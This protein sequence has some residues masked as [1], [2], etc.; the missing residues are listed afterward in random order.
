MVP[1][2]DVVLHHWNEA[3]RYGMSVAVTTR[4]GGVSP[5]PYDSLNL[6]LHVGDDPANVIANRERAA[7]AFGVDLDTTVFAHQVHGTGCTFVD[8]G[9]RGRGARGQ[10]DAIVGTDI[11]V[12]TSDDVTLVM[13]VA[14]CVPMVLI[15]PEAK[16]MAAAHAGWRGTADG[17]AANVVAAMAQR[18][19]R[20]DR[21]V[22]Y[23]GP[24]VSSAHYQ[25]GAD[26][27][28][29]LTA[30]VRPSSLDPGV[31][32]AD[33]AAH[34]RVDLIAANR[35]QLQLAGV[36]PGHLFDSGTATSHGDYFS[37]RAARP[38]GRFALMA[39]LVP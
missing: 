16:V 25:V 36:P 32:K 4:H 13:L 8:G 14:D 10:H 20:P 27:F 3:P 38:C 28:D 5:E 21:T 1:T 2:D 30:A 33:G 17:V 11:M 26:V 19:A 37:D 31:A 34:W 29:G 22:A 12:T 24:A 7:H 15:D 23:L 18:G 39:R 9:D 6:G 35:Q